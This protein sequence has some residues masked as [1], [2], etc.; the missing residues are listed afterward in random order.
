MKI[1]RAMIAF[2]FGCLL[3]KAQ[4]VVPIPNVIKF[5]GYPKIAAAAKDSGEVVLRYRIDENG[6][7]VNI[8]FKSGVKRLFKFAQFSLSKWKYPVA[9]QPS[10][11]G[12]DFEITFVYQ[13]V[14]EHGDIGF[15]CVFPQKVVIRGR[16]IAIKGN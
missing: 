9:N 1:S 16:S 4:E 14:D 3:C 10:I 5:S 12:R 2:A 6:N 8:S 13:L 11:V 7:V 15:E